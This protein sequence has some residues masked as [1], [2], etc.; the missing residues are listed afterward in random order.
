MGNI[1]HILCEIFHRNWCGT[2]GKQAL[3]TDGNFQPKFDAKSSKRC[4]RKTSRK[5]NQT[6]KFSIQ[7]LPL[8][9]PS[10]YLSISCAKCCVVVDCIEYFSSVNAKKPVRTIAS[11]CMRF[12]FSVSGLTLRQFSSIIAAQ[13][14]RF[15]SL[16]HSSSKNL[17]AM[18]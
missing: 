4:H 2:R 5:L 9:P 7:N 18:T 15:L 3:K 10:N 8:R 16:S 14:V 11:I 6:V 1:N 17:C 12:H 13:F